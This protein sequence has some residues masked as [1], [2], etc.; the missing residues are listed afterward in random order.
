MTK[1]RRPRHGSDY[2]VA[3][4]ERVVRMYRRRFV[5]AW[6]GAIASLLLWAGGSA[7]AQAVDACSK[8]DSELVTRGRAAPAYTKEKAAA[9]AAGKPAPAPTAPAPAPAPAAPAPAPAPPAP[10][11]NRARQAALDDFVGR[12]SP[13]NV[14]LSSLRLAGGDPGSV[15]FEDS[16]LASI[17]DISNIC[18][19][20]FIDHKEVRP[21][22]VFLEAPDN[23]PQHLKVVF[24]VPVTD[25]YFFGTVHYTFVGILTDQ[26][27]PAIFSYSADFTVTN[28]VTFAILT[29]LF[30]AL[31]YG[32]LAWATLEDTEGKR[33][34]PWLIYVLSPVRISA[35]AFG[36]ASLSQL[37]VILFTLIVAGLLF[38]LWLR[39]GVLSDLSQQ[40]LMLLGISAVGAG[41]AKLTG[42]IKT[43]LS[44]STAQFLMAKGWYAW[45]LQPLSE[46]A[47]FAQLLLTDGR[48]DVYKFQMAIF[49]VVVA[50][51]VISAG[52]NDLANVKISETLLYLI[53]ISQGVY[54]GGKAVTDRTTDLEN[55]VAKMIEL[56]SQIHKL[57]APA[58]ATA[59]Q[60]D[61]LIADYQKAGRVA[62]IEFAYLQH[63]RAPMVNHE[64]DPNILLP[65]G[66]GAGAGGAGAGAGGAGA[67]AGGAGAGAGSAGAGAG[68]A[69][70]GAR[71]VPT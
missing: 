62:V 26:T 54:V 49:T 64:I 43:G 24:K 3:F 7:L 42:T 13:F 46:K 69:G 8:L 11:D 36:D 60:R 33:G 20:A 34:L 61:P 29:L 44:D 67:G 1:T 38:Q 25:N 27:P 37:Q 71:Q 4:S 55:A 65:T 59:A 48:L 31:A 63:R 52:Q 32:F 2:D 51:Y 70:A 66:A 5:A 18:V 12:P 23:K 41:A 35:G 9:T 47:T 39:A 58:T 30:V 53:G 56:E 21:E 68:A 17:K 45:P 22:K 6:A 57:A 50:A 16:R 40:L 28:K 14:I 15:T 10:D 19:E